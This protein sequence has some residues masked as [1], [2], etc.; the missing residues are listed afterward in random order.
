M[1]SSPLKGNSGPRYRHMAEI[2]APYQTIRVDQLTPI[3]G[4]EI[5]GIVKSF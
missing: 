5:A 3:I 2:G 1:Q 4:A